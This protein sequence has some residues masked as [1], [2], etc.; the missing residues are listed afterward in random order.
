MRLAGGQGA[1]VDNVG[2]VLLDILGLLGQR[3]TGQSHETG[4]GGLE[5]TEGAD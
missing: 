3:R 1:G 2:G 5:D 4:T